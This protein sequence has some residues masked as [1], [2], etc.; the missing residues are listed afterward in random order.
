[1]IHVSY[2]IS[3]AVERHVDLTAGFAVI[4]RELFRGQAHGDVEANIAVLQCSDP[5]FN[6][7][8][9]IMYR[10]YVSNAF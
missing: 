8:T 1:M 4:A 5:S 7:G 9:Q 6:L 10:L 2:N 3:L